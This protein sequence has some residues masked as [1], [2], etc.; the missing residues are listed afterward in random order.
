MTPKKNL[1]PRKAA[2]ANAETLLHKMS[3]NKN[4]PVA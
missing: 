3:A 2:I 4:D 1:S